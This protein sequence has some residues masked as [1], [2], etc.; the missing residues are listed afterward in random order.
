MNKQMY[1]DSENYTGYHLHVGNWKD[2]LNPLIEGIAWVRQDGSMDLFFEDFKT[3]CERKELFIDK[4]YFCEK[5]LGG[6]IGTVKTDEEAYVMFQKWVDEV[7]YPYRNKGK[8]S[9]EGTE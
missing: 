8:T 6:Y 5:F 2:E 1:F 9:C 4:G 7:L 3:D